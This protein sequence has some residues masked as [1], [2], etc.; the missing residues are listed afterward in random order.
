[1][2]F[3]YFNYV[4]FLCGYIYKIIINNF[5]NVHIDKSVRFKKNP[6]IQISKRGNLYIGKNSLLNSSNLNYHINIHSRCKVVISESGVV[7]IGRDTLIHGTS[8]NCRKSITIG[9]RVLIAANTHIMDS[10]GHKLCLDNPSIR[11]K[12]ID[13]PR[14]VVIEDDVW[15]GCNCT[16]LPTAK[17]KNGAVVPAGTVVKG[18][19]PKIRCYVKK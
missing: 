12:T 15:V 19:F 8:I 14:I 6:I 7:N 16:I 11:I 1:M 17:I 13:E 9:D 10:N 5:L 18:I 2:I 4:Q 3:K